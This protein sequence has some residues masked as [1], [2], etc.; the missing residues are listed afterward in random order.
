MHYSISAIQR[1]LARRILPTHSGDIVV[2]VLLTSRVDT[3]LVP[4]HPCASLDQP[5][6]VRCCPHPRSLHSRASTHH[7]QSSSP[8]Y[9]VSLQTPVALTEDSQVF[10]RE[11]DDE[12]PVALYT[13]GHIIPPFATS[14]NGVQHPFTFTITLALALALKSQFGRR[15]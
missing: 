8:F 11:E 13:P 1:H 2:S 6:L 9:R 5:P 4:H 12:P 14:F 3:R 10:S 15:D 7:D